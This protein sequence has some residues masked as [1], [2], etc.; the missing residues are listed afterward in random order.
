MLSEAL[1]MALVPATEEFV[2]AIRV[3]ESREESIAKSLIR[4]SVTF[5]KANV[6]VRP[7]DNSG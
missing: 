6:L 2:E 1:V 3:P 7:F 4:S 5:T